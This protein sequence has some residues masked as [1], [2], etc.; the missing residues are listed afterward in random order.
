MNTTLRPVLAAEDEES[1]AYILRLATKRAGLPHPLV[2]VRDGQQAIDYLAG[3]PPYTDRTVHPLP[4]LLVLDLKMPRMS[5]FDVL[6]WLASRREFQSLPVVILSSS[7][8]TLDI[9]KAQQL[10]A[11]DYFVKPTL[12]GDLVKIIEILHS[13]WL[14]PLESPPLA[15][16]HALPTPFPGG[17]S[18]QPLPVE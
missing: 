12:I 13:R 2:V 14:P 10:G 9:Q 16:A 6:C 1:D 4:A 18:L 3:N 11:C 7:S 8:D 5:G 15:P 17:K